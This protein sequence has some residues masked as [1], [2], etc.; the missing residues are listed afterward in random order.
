MPK[1]LVR[2]ISTFFYVGY[3]PLVPGTAASLAGII[4]YFLVRNNVTIYCLTL[5]ALLILGFLASGRAEEL[6]QKKDHSCVVIDEVCGMLLSLIFLPYNI[7]LVIIAFFIFRALDTL[8][9]FPAGRLERMR[10]S[11][12][13]MSDDIAAGV[14]TNI[15]LQAV[16]I[17]ASLRA[18]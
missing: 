17:F 1:F 12:G 6:M 3:F 18:S 11:F 9:P 14:Y 16:A 13:I 5:A 4:V 8:K 2:I 15:I 10:G 7:K